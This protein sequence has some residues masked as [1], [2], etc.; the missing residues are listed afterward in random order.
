MAKVK[1][2][3]QGFAEFCKEADVGRQFVMEEAKSVKGNE[4]EEAYLWGMLEASIEAA[5]LSVR[6]ERRLQMASNVQG[7]VLEIY[8]AMQNG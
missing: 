6:Q 2:L 5:M 1:N 7:L 8:E 4:N 3:A